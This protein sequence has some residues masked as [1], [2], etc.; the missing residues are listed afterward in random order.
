MS[1]TNGQGGLASPD[2]PGIDVKTELPDIDGLDTADGLKRVGNNIRLYR[3]LLAKFRD[4]NTKSAEQIRRA[5]TD[6]D[7]ELAQRLA[8][9]VKGVSG[10]LGALEM[11]TA[12]ANLESQIIQGETPTE[13]SLLEFEPG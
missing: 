11:Q 7:M 9:T 12:A 5:L 1:R 8:H 4:S 13:Q 2:Q 10:N 6:G 3:K